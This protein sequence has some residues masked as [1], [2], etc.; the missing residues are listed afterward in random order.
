ME[1]RNIW[2]FV[3]KFFQLE[4]SQDLLMLNH[5]LVVYSILCLNNIPLYGYSTF[6]LSIYQLVDI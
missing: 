1:S 6:Y 3:S 2:P 4:C 5:V